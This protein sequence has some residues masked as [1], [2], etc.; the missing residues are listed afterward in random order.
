VPRSAGQLL[1]R[2]RSRALYSLFER[3]TFTR[4][5]LAS[6]GANNRFRRAHPGV[7]LPPLRLLWD[8]QSH[9]DYELYWTS[10]LA[11]AAF[12]WSLI[13]T[14]LPVVPGV[15][16]SVCEWGCGPGRIVRH[17]PEL[18]AD[19]AVSLFGTDYND[20]SIAWCNAHISAVTFFHNELAPPLPFRSGQLDALYCRSVFT[21]LSEEMHHQWIAELKRVVR[22]AGLIVISTQGAAH[23]SRLL[24]E[25]RDQYARGEL[26]VRRLAEEG[27]LFFSAFHSPRFVREKLLVGMQVEEHQE[28]RTSQDVWV[29]RR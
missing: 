12:Y 24:P 1:I 19:H 16:V 9:T 4:R 17:L 10:G 13:R 6:R 7:S 21:H 27:K 28:G 15:A 2:S 26:V 5:A 22:P 23:L 18:C 20:A 29:V 3:L 11:S 8:A 14:K 25:E